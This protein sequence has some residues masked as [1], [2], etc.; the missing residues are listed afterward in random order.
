MKKDF[1]EQDFGQGEVD[2]PNLLD[3]AIFI[4]A[5]FILSLAFVGFLVA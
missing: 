4:S 5:C 1:A 2:R 3:I